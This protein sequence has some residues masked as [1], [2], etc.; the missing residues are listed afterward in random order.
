[1]QHLIHLIGSV[2]GW[3]GMIVVGLCLVLLCLHLGFKIYARI[4]KWSLIVEAMSEYG[5]RHPEKF[6]RFRAETTN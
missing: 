4:V 1:M 2:L 3:L 5:K 6:R